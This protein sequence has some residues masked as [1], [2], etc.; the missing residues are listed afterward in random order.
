ML[1]DPDLNTERARSEAAARHEVLE[2]GGSVG[3]FKRYEVKRCI[4]EGGMGRI[5]QAYDPVLRRDVAVKVMR[6]DVPD[7]ERRRFRRE[8]IH[9]ARFSHPSIVRIFDMGEQQAPDGRSIEWFSMEYLPG[10]DLERV[11]G[12][13][14][15]HG[16]RLPVLSVL[17]IFRQ[18]LS[19]LQYAHECFVVHRDVKPA[20]IYVTRD[21]NTRFLTTKLLD[22]GIALDLDGP[23]G[24]EVL[25]GNPFYMAPEQTAHGR[26]IDFRADVYAAGLSFYEAVTGRHPLDDFRNAAIDTVLSAQ[27]RYDPPPPSRFLPPGTPARLAQAVDIIF[28]RA[29]AKEP[30]DRFQSA[31]DMR[32]AMLVFL[33]PV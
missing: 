1:Q 15:S 8:A 7:A 33:S 22:F 18:V 2:I 26:Q 20:N 6:A 29:C 16:R 25:C 17:D 10:S 12:R 5:Y 9:G 14:F 19:A 28:D 30:D 13:A 3:H 24:A 4:G 31:S 21:P 32:E 23:A 27:C 11:L